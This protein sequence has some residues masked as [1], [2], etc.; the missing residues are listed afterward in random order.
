MSF[1]FYHAKYVS[2]TEGQGNLIAYVNIFDCQ[3]SGWVN[4]WQSK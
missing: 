2:V 1:L 3:F 4:F